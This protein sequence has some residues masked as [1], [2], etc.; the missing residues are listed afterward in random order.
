MAQSTRQNQLAAFV[1]AAIALQC[2]ASFLINTRISFFMSDD[3]NAVAL[4]RRTDFW[5]YITTHVDIH[6]VPLHRLVN[7]VLHTLAPMNFAAATLFMIGCHTASLLVLYR[8]LQRLNPSRINLWLILIYA[9]NGYVYLVFHWWSAALHRLP[10]ILFSIVSC[11]GFLRF[12]QE[13]RLRF[14]TI[15]LASALAAAGFFI[16]AVLIPVYWAALL[17]CLMDFRGWK[18]YTSE[19]VLIAIGLLLSLAYVGWYT[20]D[21]P[22]DVIQASALGEVLRDSIYIGLSTVAQMV[23]QMRLDTGIAPWINLASCVA[24]GATIAFAPRAWRALLMGFLV[25]SVNLM[26]IASS[27]RATFFGA[28]VMLTPY[29]YA[30]LLFLLAMFFTVMVRHVN[31]SIPQHFAVVQSHKSMALLAV[32]FSL[33]YAIAGW[34]TAL[35]DT[36]PGPDDDHWKSARFARNFTHDLEHTAIANLNL[37]DRLLPGHFRFGTLLRKPLSSSEFLSWYGLH[38]PF[39]QLEQ[40]LSFIDTQGHIQPLVAQSKPIPLQSDAVTEAQAGCLNGT[41]TVNGLRFFTPAPTALD[42][43]YLLI[44]YTTERD[45]TAEMQLLAEAAPG[46]AHIDFP[47]AKNYRLVD[48][49]RFG[50]FDP[51]VLTGTRIANLSPTLCI[52]AVDLTH[53]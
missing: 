32:I 26:M 14:A 46:S 51:I 21:N 37:V 31:A 28:L 19:Y 43:A 16:K 22:Y 33:G 5:S 20:Y 50:K 41:N 24:L 25:I 27:S 17:F 47:A 45:A 4:L 7:Y 44:R 52:H 8:A 1:I 30:E 23:L 35:I 15:A 49:S 39:Q 38:P 53:Y 18:K 6:Q 48:L 40:P 42:R 29:Y 34:R 12:H 2:I 10:Y 13:Q 36:H 11:Y 3:L 9:L